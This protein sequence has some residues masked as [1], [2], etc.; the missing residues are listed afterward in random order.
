[1][2]TLF[3]FLCIFLSFSIISQLKCIILTFIMNKAMFQPWILKI[4]A[5]VGLWDQDE[6]REGCIWNDNW[7]TEGAGIPRGGSSTS[8]SKWVGSR[9]KTQH[10]GLAGKL[11]KKPH[12]PFSSPRADFTPQ[13]E[14][15]SFFSA[16]HS[17]VNGSCGFHPDQQESAGQNNQPPCFL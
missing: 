8:K 2:S 5:C 14:P 10:S 3:L 12:M 13:S 7:R 16:R 15:R 9:R 1:M 17:L 6:L 4:R 11:L